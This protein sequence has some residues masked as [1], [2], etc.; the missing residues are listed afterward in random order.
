MSNSLWCHGQYSLLVNWEKWKVKMLAARLCLTLYDTM[1]CSLPGSSVHGILQVRVLE[2][3]TIPFSRG[4]SQGLLNCRDWTR[5]PNCRW[6]LYHLSHQ[7]ALSISYQSGNI[8]IMY[9]KEL[10]REKILKYKELLFKAKTPD[11][12]RVV[13]KEP[14]YY[15]LRSFGHSPNVHFHTRP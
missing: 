5:L 13:T 1:N 12:L 15:S 3:V 10:K 2:W 6:I 4:S 7:E 14:L 11:F 8:K 9:G